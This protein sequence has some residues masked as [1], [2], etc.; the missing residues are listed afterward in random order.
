MEV[1]V[2]AG[3]T[4]NSACLARSRQLFAHLAVLGAPML[5]RSRAQPRH[6]NFPLP[7]DEHTSRVRHAC[8]V[9]PFFRREQ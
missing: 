2:S 1:I 9:L 4:F 5:R 7:E 6:V 3:A 8:L